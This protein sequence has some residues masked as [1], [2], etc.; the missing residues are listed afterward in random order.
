MQAAPLEAATDPRAEDHLR[1]LGVRLTPD[2]GEVR[3]FSATAKRMELCLLDERDPYWVEKTVRLRRGEGGVW[4][5]SSPL[6]APGRRYSI[7]AD[8]PSGPR[9]AFNPDLHLLDPYAK[10]LVR[11]DQE[12]WRGAVVTDDFDWGGAG[13]PHTPLE[14]TVLYEAHVRGLTKQLRSVPA[15]LRG[16]YAGLAHESTIDYL[17]DLGVTAVELLPVHAST[18]ERRLMK[19]GMAN[20]WGYNT[21]GFFAPHG[22]YASL[23]AQAAGP[24]AVLEEFKGMV[25]L[26][27]EAGLEVILD[28]VYNHTAEEGRYGPT[29][30]FRGLDN[31]TYYRQGGDGRYIDTTGCGN[32]LDHSQ[33]VVQRLVLDSVRYWANEVRIDGFRFDLAVT[34]GRDGAVTYTPDSPLLA[35]LRDDPALAGVKLIA[36]PWDVGLGG[37]Q[38]GGF[39]AGWSEW[40]DRYRDTVR[41][42]WLTDVEVLRGGGWPRE[43]I[44]G[45]ATGLAG[46]SPRFGRERAP[47]ASVNFVTAHDG[48]PLADLTAYNQKHN[49]AN[50]E[51][52]R[53]GTDNNHSFNFGVEGP[54][55]NE[56]VLA[57]RRRAMRNLLGTLLLSAGVPMLLAGDEHG[58]TQR[59]NN[60]AYCHDAP[61]T[62]L[63]WR[64]ADWQRELHDSVRRLIRLRDENPALRPSRYAGD[65]GAIDG[66]TEMHWYNR[67]GV[68]MDDA[69]WLTSENR[70]LQYLART[71]PDAPG[72][73]STLVVVHGHEWPTTV[74]MPQHD[75]ITRFTPLW[76]SA[77]DAPGGAPLAPGDEV[78]V[79]GPTLLLLRAE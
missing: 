37:W 50:G 24:Q 36:E 56:A 3:V 28:V 61:V 76:S 65:D 74:V 53:D 79:D 73:N 12:T 4:S 33:E 39:P 71:L 21:V 42:F 25:R 51:S 13:K 54:T 16:T 63:D 29:T 77:D 40:N 48:F 43:G 68:R 22:Q 75:G 72:R 59:G 31:S 57:D 6:L 66:A 55:R 44:G 9:D 52:N 46:S 8:G 45:L 7:R 62:W 58:R 2:G 41:D 60:N 10:G 30:S 19:Q 5:G 1:D 15:H 11:V 32:T 64:L 47:L 78:A 14:R 23:P 49:L 17:K 35:A 70:T 69:A 26:L 34:L 38:T 20:Y 18:S 67:G 27:H